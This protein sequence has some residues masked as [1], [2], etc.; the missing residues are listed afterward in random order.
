MFFFTNS[1]STYS[2]KSEFG[3][4]KRGIVQ[5]LYLVEEA[6]FGGSANE[7]EHNCAGFTYNWCHVWLLN[8]NRR[9][10]GRFAR[11]DRFIGLPRLALLFLRTTF[12]AHDCKCLKKFQKMTT[13]Q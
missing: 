5:C 13:L 10:G 2:N 12:L 3:K 6:S 1:I 4:T 11:F 9:G 8:S 7:I